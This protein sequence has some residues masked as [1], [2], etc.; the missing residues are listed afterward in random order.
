MGLGHAVPGGRNS[1]L[2]AR[3]FE[4]RLQLRVSFP[5]RRSRSRAKRWAFT[6]GIVL[7]VGPS[8]TSKQGRTSRPRRDRHPLPDKLTPQ[9]SF[10]LGAHLPE[11]KVK[12]MQKK[13]GRKKEKRAWLN[14][15]GRS[16]TSLTQSRKSPTPKLPSRRRGDLGVRRSSR[17]D[18]GGNR[19]RP[20][21]RGA[22]GL[23]Q[24]PPACTPPILPLPP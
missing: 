2:W 17:S 16:G 21:R 8:V 4:L 19:S 13:T 11:K 1:Q 18:V 24:E 6:R 22:Q 9:S 7:Q 23:A 12:K 20:P 5:Y 3:L 14:R 15:N 10:P